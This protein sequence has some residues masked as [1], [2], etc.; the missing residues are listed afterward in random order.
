[1]CFVIFIYL[2]VVPLLKVNVLFVLRYYSGSIN[3]L[4]N[5]KCLLCG[6]KRFKISIDGL[7]Y[8]LLGY[9]LPFHFKNK[10]SLFKNI[11]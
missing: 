6:T 3:E 10:V 11:G 5:C 4:Q 8:K 2:N 1:M 7:F 9:A